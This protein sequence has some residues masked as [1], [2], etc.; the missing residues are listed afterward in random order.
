MQTTLTSA[1]TGSVSFPAQGLG[2]VYRHSHGSTGRG[3][4]PGFRGVLWLPRNYTATQLPS[5]RQLG[6]LPSTCRVGE[7]T[8]PGPTICSVNPGGWSLVEP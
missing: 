7:A 2:L 5:A 1:S 8:K 6:W 4:A 3:S